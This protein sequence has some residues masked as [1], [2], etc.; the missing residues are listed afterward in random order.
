MIKL[1]VKEFAERLNM[2]RRTLYRYIEKGIITPRVSNF[3]GMRYFTEEDVA[4]YSA[5]KEEIEEE[6]TCKNT[7][8]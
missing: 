8:I 4:F 3:N 1:N 5:K 7:Q 6:N 2:P